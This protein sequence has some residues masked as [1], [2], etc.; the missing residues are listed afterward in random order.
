M[1]G[2]V[3]VAH[4]STGQIRSSTFFPHLLTSP[5]VPHRNIH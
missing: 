5:G 2:H 4:L 1:L 3:R